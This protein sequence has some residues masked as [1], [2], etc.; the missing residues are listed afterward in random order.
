MSGI[1]ISYRREDSG[2][3][4][5]RLFD[6]LRDHFG[7][8][9]V[10]MDVTRIEPGEDFVEAI[11]RAV[12]S[13][14]VLLAVIGRQWLTC[15]D[16][17]GRRRLDNPNDLL[18]VETATALKRNV[19]VVPVLVQGAKTPSTE[20]L[21]KDL[22]RLT[23]RQAVELRDTRW[24]ADIADLITIL[25][26]ILS[27]EL[28]TKREARSEQVLAQSDLSIVKPSTQRPKT[29]KQMRS[30]AREDQRKTVVKISGFRTLGI[31][32]GLV[33]VAVVGLILFHSLPTKIIE[34]V[35]EPKPMMQ[36]S[37]SELETTLKGHDSVVYA[38]AALP[39]GRLASGSADT[40]IKIWNL[41]TGQLVT[42]LIK[43]HGEV[44]VLAALPDGRLASG[45]KDEDTI[46]IWNLTTGQAETTLKGADLWVNALAALPNGRLASGS[47][48]VISSPNKTIKIWNLK[49][50]QAE[51]TLTGLENSVTALVSLPDNRLA[52]GSGKTITIWNLKTGQNE[53]TLTGHAEEIEALAVLPDGRLASGSWDRTIKIWNLKTGQA[54]ATLT[55]HAEGI[56]ALA[57]LPDGRLAS[58]SKDRT[59]KIWNLKTGQAEETLRTQGY[60]YALAVL[61]NGRLASGL[62]NSTVTIW[63]IGTTP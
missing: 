18:R 41:R 61:P 52:S 15:T 2:G 47:G 51:E 3:H 46:I 5:G 53:A 28:P 21:P 17:T 60:V 27:S 9:R 55:G 22:K 45:D 40:T 16:E 34:S 7:K 35:T 44:S 20:A 24:D 43:H 29:K 50:G 49:T 23:R 36:R 59:I 11:D 58:G 26:K 8:K 1:F 37:S 31:I 4:A 48:A 42:T 62:G 54:K 56:F 57:V 25:E 38:L 10:F 32:V 19:R 12:G 14:D 39:D 33:A 63:A 6:R 13:C 30:V